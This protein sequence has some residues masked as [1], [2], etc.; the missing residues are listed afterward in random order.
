MLVS[1]EK[2]RSAV[3]NV[4]LE[5]TESPYPADVCG[6]PELHEPRLLD[7]LGFHF[8]DDTLVES[9]LFHEGKGERRF[10]LELRE[11]LGRPCRVSVGFHRE[12]ISLGILEGNSLGQVLLHGEK[13]TFAGKRHGDDVEE[14]FDFRTELERGTDHDQAAADGLPSHHAVLNGLDDFGD[15]QEEVEVVGQE[16][17]V[18]LRAQP[19]DRLDGVADLIQELAV[20]RSTKALK[21][22]PDGEAPALAGKHR[23]GAVGLLGE[24]AD[25]GISRTKI[26]LDH[27][28]SPCV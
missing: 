4:G 17:A 28:F 15:F 6:L 7:H 14:L 20:F 10:S 9:S 27:V 24:Q 26:I 2:C 16:D 25:G 19:V 1:R 11:T 21:A 3:A 12:S 5:G 22:I 8:G 13:L 18:L 23:F